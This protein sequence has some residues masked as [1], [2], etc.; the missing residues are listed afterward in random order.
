MTSNGP[1]TT[2]FPQFSF[3]MTSQ[4]RHRAAAP[5]VY[6]SPYDPVCITH[7]HPRRSTC[8]MHVQMLIFSGKIKAQNPL[9]AVFPNQE[10]WRCSSQVRP[11]SDGT[12]SH[13]R[14]VLGHDHY[15]QRRDLQSPSCNL[16]RAEYILRDVW[17][18]KMEGEP[19]RIAGNA[20]PKILRVG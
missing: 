1:H 18:W 2:S 14:R 12:P 13:V 10:V 17:E 9:L 19:S 15:L 4:A 5:P 20:K 16:V 7:G 8:H 3:D 6:R 11:A